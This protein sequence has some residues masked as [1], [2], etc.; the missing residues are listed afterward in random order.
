MAEE[1]SQPEIVEHLGVKLAQETLT[2]LRE[3]FA[4]L[5]AGP[6]VDT[7]QLHEH[8]GLLCSA[9]GQVIGAVK[10]LQF[11]VSILAA[12]NLLTN[13][14]ADPAHRLTSCP[15]C[16]EVLRFTHE[17]ETTAGHNEWYINCPK[18][19]EKIRSA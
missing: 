9:V 3:T 11:H 2:G 15:G 4:R 6:S 16:F 12:Q 8:L 10:Q 14:W 19:G 5:A 1:K 17:H 13:P 18:C 7:T